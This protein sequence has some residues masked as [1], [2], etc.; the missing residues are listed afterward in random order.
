MYLP[1]PVIFTLRS[2]IFMMLISVLLLPF[3]ELPLSFLIKQFRVMNTLSFYLFGNVLYLVFFLFLKDSFAMYSICGWQLFSFNVLNISSQLSWPKKF[4]LRNLPVILW[5]ILCMWRTVFF[6]ATFKIL[7]CLLTFD[8]LTIMCLG[9]AYLG[10][11]Y[12]EFLRPH[13]SDILFSQFWEVFY[14]YCF[15]YTLCPFSFFY[16]DSRNADIV[17]I[18]SPKSYRFY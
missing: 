9:V 2:Y 6:L 7:S 5:G 14:H 1:L 3:K 17:S 12:W 13:G 15:K 10:S 8:N 18:V 4:L 16:W 11:A